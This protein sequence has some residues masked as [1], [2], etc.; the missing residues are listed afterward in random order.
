[1]LLATICALLAARSSLKVA[2]EWIDQA[3]K[4]AGESASQLKDVNKRYLKKRYELLKH[5]ININHKI[6]NVSLWANRISSKLT[7]WWVPTNNDMSKFNQS[8][9]EFSQS[10]LDLDN[11]D[12]E[13]F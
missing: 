8:I 3:Q 12:I 1:M 11:F 2:K 9:S 13:N 6:S 7:D 10:T 5:E 4:I